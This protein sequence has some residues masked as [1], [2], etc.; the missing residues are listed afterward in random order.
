MARVLA[1]DRTYLA[2][3]AELE[4]IGIGHRLLKGVALAN[5]LYA[6]PAVRSYAD[7]DV[8]LERDGLQRGLDALL[9][10]GGRR[11]LPEVR[12][13]FDT[14]FGKD[15]T[16]LFEAVPVD[17]HRTLIAGP[18]GERL[19]MSRL[20]SR[21]REVTIGER[22]RAP[23]LDTADTYV[24]AAL[25]AGAADL[26]AKLVTLRDLLELEHAAGF[27]PNSPANGHRSGASRHRWPGRC[28]CW[29]RRCDRTPSRRFSAGQRRTGL[30]TRTLVHELLHECQESELPPRTGRH[31]G[32]AHVARSRHLRRSDRLPQRST[33]TPAV[34]HGASTSPGRWRVYALTWPTGWRSGLQP[35]VMVR[36]PVARC[37]TRSSR[38]VRRATATRLGTVTIAVAVIGAELVPE[39]FVRSTTDPLPAASAHPGAFFRHP[40]VIRKLVVCVVPARLAPSRIRCPWR[41]RTCGCCRVLKP[42]PVATITKPPVGTQFVTVCA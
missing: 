5:G 39:Q 22:A 2:V 42:G 40:P 36:G 38:S 10:L 6:D 24:H 3:A 18:Y 15:I 28:D 12:P 23:A 7:A 34:G 31:R 37:R 41:R 30:V 8:L 19:P 27:D 20:M 13:G 25:T 35:N 1:V 9:A 14:R 32:P 33:S 11:L 17:V 29:P 4:R 21:R 16:L 26:P